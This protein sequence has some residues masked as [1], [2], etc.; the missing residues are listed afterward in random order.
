MGDL[1]Q[2]SQGIPET[3]DSTKSYLSTD[4][5]GNN[6]NNNNN[7]AICECACYLSKFLM[8]FLLVTM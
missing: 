7:N 3:M 4:G 6:N 8:L 1:F 5:D 2:D